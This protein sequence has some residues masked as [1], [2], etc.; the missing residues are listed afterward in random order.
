MGEELLTPTRL[1][2]KIVLPLLD[3]F[4]IKGLV[5]MTGGGFQENIPRALPED[6]Q[7]A[8]ETTAWEPPAIFGLLQKWGSVPSFEMYRTFNMGIGL[9]MIAPELEAEQLI[10]ALAQS[11][12]MAAIIGRLESGPRKTLL[13]GLDHE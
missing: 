13:K 9:V 5:H 2:P 4:N 11:G 3:R 6:L 12:E 1:Y 10:S 7:A 8:V